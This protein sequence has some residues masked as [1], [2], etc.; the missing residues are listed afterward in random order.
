[1]IIKMKIFKVQR[2][3]LITTIANVTNKL[4]KDY[5]EILIPADRKGAVIL[6]L[7]KFKHNISTSILY[8]EYDISKRAMATL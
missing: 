5:P 3:T 1:M 4:K 7:I 8:L 2:K 6:S